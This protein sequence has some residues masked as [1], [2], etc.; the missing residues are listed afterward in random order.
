MT[1]INSQNKV[2]RDDDKCGH[3]LKEIPTRD[4]S[5]L[6]AAILTAKQQNRLVLLI[7]TT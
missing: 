7:F 4:P 3:S 6:S 1:G 2:V 5:L